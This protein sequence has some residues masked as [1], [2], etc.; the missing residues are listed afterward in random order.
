MQV[1]KCGMLDSTDISKNTY[2]NGMVHVNFH[3]YYSGLWA[4]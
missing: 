2:L 4:G 3:R 1:T